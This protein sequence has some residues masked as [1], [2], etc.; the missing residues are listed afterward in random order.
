MFQSY[1]EVLHLLVHAAARQ[2][3]DRRMTFYGHIVAYDAKNHCVKVQIPT[4][5]V[6]ESS[7]GVVTGWI[8]L[9]SH[10][11]GNG[12]GA[13]FAPEADASGI[14]TTTPTGTPCEIQLNEQDGAATIVALRYTD[15]H[16]APFPNMVA[17]EFA[18]KSKAGSYIY[19][20]KDGSAARTFQK[21]PMGNTIKETLDAQG[22]LSFLLPGGAQVSATP[23]GY[24]VTGPGEGG[25]GGGASPASVQLSND[26]SYS[27]QNSKCFV[28]GTS[29]GAVAIENTFGN[30]EI[31]E[32]G[33]ITLTTLGMV[34]TFNHLL[35]WTIITLSGV[36]NIP[37]VGPMVVSSTI[38][39]QL[40][41]PTNTIKANGNVLG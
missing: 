24:S 40:V 9:G 23:T 13:Q 37:L 30:V 17:G 6:D 25:G 12:W 5:A 16:R 19:Y 35:G 41:A 28:I 38:G 33:I 27:V 32:E 4:L 26:G 10:M 7:P 31:N 8:P 29:D 14:Q 20:F 34:M 15:K 21:D 1:D 22:N 2:Q 36:I 18:L 3:G 11:V 39:I